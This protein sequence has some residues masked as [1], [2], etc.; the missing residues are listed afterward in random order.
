MSILRLRCHCARPCASGY[1]RVEVDVEGHSAAGCRDGRF[2]HFDR[3]AVYSY[4]RHLGFEPTLGHSP[5]SVSRAIP[6]DDS[7]LLR[8]PPLHERLCRS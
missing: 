6:E 8:H 3:A 2:A 1:P 4:S 5:A 7:F